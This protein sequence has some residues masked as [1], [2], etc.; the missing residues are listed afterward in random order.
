M[1][2]FQRLLKAHKNIDFNSKRA[3]IAT[4]VKLY[5]SSYR[6][7]GAR[8]LMT[9]DGHWTGAISGGCLEGDALRKARKA[10][11]ENKP[12]VVTYDTINDE[13]ARGIGVALGCNGIIDVLIEPLDKD[14]K[15]DAI[16]MLNTTQEYNDT[17][18]IATIFRLEGN[19]NLKIGNRVLL[20]PDG[21]LESRIQDEQLLEQL[22]EDMHDVQKSRKSLNKE[23]TLP[24]G[25]VEVFIEAINPSIH[26]YIFGGGYDAI[27]V[28]TLANHLGWYVSVADDCPAHLGPKRFPNANEVVCIPRDATKESVSVN[29]Y[30]AA[31]LMSHNYKYDF[32]VLK[33]L[34]QTDIRYIGLLGPKKRFEKMQEEMLEEG[35]VLKDS[36][37]DRIHNPIGLDI[38]AET[39]EEIALSMVAE[40]QAKFNNKGGKFLKDKKGFIHDRPA[41]Q[42]MV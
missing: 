16:S 13:D 33:Q 42:E 11:L 18:V 36:D 5:G 12:T 26:L 31:I 7:P 20:L 14:G 1:N 28:S 22:T 4:V 41:E 35:I 9:E 6:R 25:Q 38:G 23:Y 15:S 29:N 2:E 40:I 21:T 17:A 8:M 19:L 39:P 24:L 32:E 37:F 34:L 27:P 3:A 10:I 30:T